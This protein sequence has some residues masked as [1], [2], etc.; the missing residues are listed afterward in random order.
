ML[1]AKAIYQGDLNKLEP[2]VYEFTSSLIS[3]G[4]GLPE[5]CEERAED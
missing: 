5:I 1:G 3:T 4:L 2:R